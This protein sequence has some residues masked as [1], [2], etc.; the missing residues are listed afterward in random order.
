MTEISID[1]MTAL[2]VKVTKQKGV[3]KALLFA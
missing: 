1:A 3:R 2:G